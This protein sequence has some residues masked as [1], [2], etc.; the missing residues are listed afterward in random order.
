M[1]T[2]LSVERYH[3]YTEWMCPMRTYYKYNKAE[4]S[5]GNKPRKG[6]I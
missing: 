4:A 6:E 2:E 1:M 3:M 5:E